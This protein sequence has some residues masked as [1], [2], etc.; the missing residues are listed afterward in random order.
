MRFIEC[1]CPECAYHY[2][3][4][5]DLAG[6]TVLCPDCQARFKPIN[7]AAASQQIR[8][9]KCDQ[10][11]TVKERPIVVLP[12]I[13]AVVWSLCVAAVGLFGL[14]YITGL[15]QCNG[16][17]QEASLAANACVWIITAYVV[18]RAIDS[19]IRW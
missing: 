2:E 12:I 19:A 11:N 10:S 8:S 5:E 6:K 14:L 16:A 1:S 7:P 9:R 17:I 3:I 18:A 15:A 4:A 13:R